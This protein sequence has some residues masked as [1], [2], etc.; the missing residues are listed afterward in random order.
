MNRT[1]LHNAR[2]VLPGRTAMG[3]V[4]LRGR[5]I[6]AVGMGDLPEAFLSDSSA[7][8]TDLG[9]DLLM[10]GAI[11][12]H[13]HFRDPGLT[14]KADIA[15]ESLAA[16]LGGVTSVIDMP[17]TIPP[18][19]SPEAWE[20]KME[21]AR[22]CSS[23]NYAFYIGLTGHNTG[24]IG[25]TD[26]T[27]VPA[28][29][30]FMGTTTG[31][32]L[33]DSA[34]ALDRIF[35]A[36]ARADALVV[37][38]AEDD[39]I[40]A[41]DTGEMVRRYGSPEAVPVEEHPSVRTA[42][43]CAAATLQAL[44]LSRLH[45]TRIHLAH[46]STAL[47][48]KMLEM[49]ATSSVTWETCPQ[50]LLLDRGDYTRLGARMKCNPAIKSA[51]DR[52]A[53]VEAA[54]RG[55]LSTIA[56]DHAPHLLS[57]KEGGALKAASGMPGVQFALPLMVDL[58]GPVRAAALMA[59]NP[60]R[61]FRIDRRGSIAPG[62][63]ADLTVLN[64][65]IPYKTITDHAVASRCAWTPYDSMKCATSVRATMVNGEWA[66]SPDGSVRSDLRGAPLQFT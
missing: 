27:A 31:N 26:R 41:R 20:A 38:H 64:T 9:G 11:D 60:A 30:L 40:I 19:T 45:G 25:R 47:E 62:N 32:M 4:A 66:V 23:V 37:I 48:V 12:T 49:F 16:A 63:Y 65:D 14:D 55:P 35:E 52:L 15:T 17:N 21:R 43:A 28:F 61:I 3:Y 50:Y 1:I 22:E 2:L 54:R 51:A 34:E 33:V 39:A 42:E 53:L 8:I 59:E 29:K 58:L 57:S 36:A 46:I 10:P 5:M 7:R 13:V 6:E 56:T 44:E 24:L 18:T